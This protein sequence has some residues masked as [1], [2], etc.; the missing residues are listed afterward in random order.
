MNVHWPPNPWFNRTPL[1]SPRN[2]CD[3]ESNVFQV[4]ERFM[5]RI[6]E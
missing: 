6:H 1:G 4:R 5:P 2:A 3:P